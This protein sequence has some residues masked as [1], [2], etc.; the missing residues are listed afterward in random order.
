MSENNDDQPTVEAYDELQNPRCPRLG[1]VVTFGYCRAEDH[2]QPCRK[3]VFCWGHRFDVVKYLR[4]HFGADVLDR[5]DAA[6][7]DKRVSLVDLI[8]R[9]KRAGGQTDSGGP[10]T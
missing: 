9:A 7:P 5:M 2:G 1:D 8:E 10:Q 3:T 4:V 6:P